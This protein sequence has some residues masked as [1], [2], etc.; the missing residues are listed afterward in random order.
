[1]ELTLNL[2]GK[3]EP[4]VPHISLPPFQFQHNNE[5]IHFLTV[6]SDLGSGII[7]TPLIAVLANIAIAKSLSKNNYFQYSY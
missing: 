6:C 2:K 5:T 4:G 7:I 3:V 1:M